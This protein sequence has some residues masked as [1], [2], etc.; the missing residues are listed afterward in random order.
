MQTIEINKGISVGFADIIRGIQQL[1]N[2]SLAKFAGEINSLVSKRNTEQPHLREL[3]LLKKIKN[4]IPASIKR[5]QKQLFAKMQDDTLT[6]PEH[7]ELVLLN[8]MI[9][10][11]TAERIGFMGELAQLRQITLP[12]L[13]RQLSNKTAYE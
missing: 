8:G 13:N 10:E 7:E 9:E 3:E 2:H 4:P 11:K 5:R 6:T 12:E 1:D